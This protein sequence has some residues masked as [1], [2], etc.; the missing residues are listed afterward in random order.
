[1]LV[2]RLPAVLARLAASLHD[3][4]ADPIR[5]AMA[6]FGRSDITASLEFGAEQAA[7]LGFPD[8]ARATER[9]AALTAADRRVVCHG[10]LHLFNVIVDGDRPQLI[11]WTVARLAHPAYDVAFSRLLF[12]HPPIDVPSAAAPVVRGAGQLMSRRFL[13]AYRR[14]ARHD[15]AITPA[16]LDVYEAAHGHR[17][18]L[19]LAEWE[20]SGLGP[21]DHPWRSLAPVVARTIERVT[22]M[23]VSVP[24]VR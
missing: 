2:R 1:M 21:T 11:D 6:P 10:D 19:E 12:R 4:D 20:A 14:T 5:V 22:G 15:V 16:A 23:P 13:S 7:T 9:L 18:L 24:G 8:L 3:L 17:I